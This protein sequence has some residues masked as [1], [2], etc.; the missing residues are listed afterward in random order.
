MTAKAA[1][2]ASTACVRAPMSRCTASKI[3]TAD[4]QEQQRGFGKRGDAFDL[5]V[6]VLMFGVGRLA[7]NA[8]GEI[9]QHRRREVDQR[10]AGLGQDG[11]RAGEQADD[12]L[13]HGQPRRG[14]NRAERGLFLVVHL[15]PLAGTGYR[16]RI[17]ASIGG[18]SAVCIVILVLLLLRRRAFPGAPCFQ[19]QVRRDVRAPERVPVQARLR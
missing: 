16:A 14:G 12:G 6:A 18:R 13:C 2:V 19:P 17:A 9:G 11:E 5:A 8:H 7:G 1:T 10:M 4:E 3:T 15:R